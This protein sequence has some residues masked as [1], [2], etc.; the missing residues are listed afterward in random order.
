ML[1]ELFKN[2][3]KLFYGLAIALFILGGLVTVYNRMSKN[4]TIPDET[5]GFNNI[6][7]QEQKPLEIYVHIAGAVKRP[8][9]YRFDP[10]CRAADAVIAA[11]GFVRN[12]DEGKINL[13]QPLKD[14]Q[15]LD[16][17]F[18]GEIPLT[19]KA[20][21]AGKEKKTGKGAE[22]ININ[23]ADEKGLENIPC[24]GPSL[25]KKIAD[26]RT[27]NGPFQ[28]IEDLKNV[29][30]VGDKKFEKLRPYITVN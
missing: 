19:T 16:I 13:A 4:P 8:G 26:F 30:G 17:P 22:I 3:K 9:L 24:V 29:P 6:Q 27:V 15:K 14:G 21:E 5:Q 12:A 7:V 2:N 18:S 11:G 1:E 25:A 28:N 20:K 10:S 23:S